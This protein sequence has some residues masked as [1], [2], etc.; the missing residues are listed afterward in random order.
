MPQPPWQREPCPSWCVREHAEDD[1]AL[2]RYHQGEPSS[3][4]VLMSTGPEE[5][6]G[7]TFAPVEL[8]LRLARYVDEVV[9]WVAIEPV[10]PFEPRMVLTAESA[11]RLVERTSAL[12]TTLDSA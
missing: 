12:L 8:T 3:V 4:T 11:R 5:P 7:A 6:R 2:D 10:R 1:I 9:E